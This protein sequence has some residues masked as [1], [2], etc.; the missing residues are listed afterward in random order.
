[1]EEAPGRRSSESKVPEVG[2]NL[3]HPRTRTISVAGAEGV[4]LYRG[5]RVKVGGWEYEGP[6]KRDK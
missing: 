3:G 5:S 2:M 1:M 4:R 6:A